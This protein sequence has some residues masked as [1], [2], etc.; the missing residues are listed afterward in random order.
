MVGNQRFVGVDNFGWKLYI[1]NPLADMEK[2]QYIKDS[3]RIYKEI[4][5]FLSSSIISFFIDYILYTILNIFTNKLILSN[6]IA[7]IVSATV[8][9]N[10][11]KKSPTASFV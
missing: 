3:I 6:I 5:K 1:D 7:R 2:P 10:I 8:N 9:Y 11:N 4:F